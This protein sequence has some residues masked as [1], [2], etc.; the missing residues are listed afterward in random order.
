MLLETYARDV[1]LI[2]MLE[3]C[4]VYAH[5][6][7]AYVS[8]VVCVSGAKKLGY[9]RKMGKRTGCTIEL[10]FPTCAPT[11]QQ[12]ATISMCPGG[13]GCEGQRH[14]WGGADLWKRAMR[15]S[16]TFDDDCGMCWE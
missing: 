15:L 16:H 3:M 9:K 7:R 5:L 1:C 2:R 14:T 8:T 13:R 11:T 6:V 10:P 4:Y 12:G